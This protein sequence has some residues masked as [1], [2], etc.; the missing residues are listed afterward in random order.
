MSYLLQS[1]MTTCQ[2]LVLG[3]EFGEQGTSS[4]KRSVTTSQVL[5]RGLRGIEGSFRD[6]WLVTANLL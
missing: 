6:P 2:N 4:Y 1:L 3:E 5:K